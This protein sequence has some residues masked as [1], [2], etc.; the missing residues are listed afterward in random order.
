M[1]DNSINQTQKISKKNYL[2]TE[3]INLGSFSAQKI[4]SDLQDLKVAETKNVRKGVETFAQTER[5]TKEMLA[6][7][8]SNPFRGY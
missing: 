2:T 3:Q 8:L 6:L 4:S 1:E 7:K 5:A